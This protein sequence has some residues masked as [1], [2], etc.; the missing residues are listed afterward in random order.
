MKSAYI[1]LTV[2]SLCVL[3]CDPPIY[4]VPIEGTYKKEIGFECGTIDMEC[5]TIG[6]INFTIKQVY[7]TTNAVKISPQS[8]SVKHKDKVVKYTTYLNGNVVKE[9][10]NVLNGD[11]VVV[12]FI[13]KV[14]KNDTVTVNLDNFLH[15]NEKPINAGNI[16][17]VIK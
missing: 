8:L 1:Y 9:L 10:Q 2:L 3:S 4:Q 6:G 12:N 7:H 17:F 15:C 14:S 11:I 13:E 5:N 16:H